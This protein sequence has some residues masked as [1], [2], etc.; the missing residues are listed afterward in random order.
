[1]ESTGQKGRIQVSQA[2]ADIL[3]DAG[4]AHWLTKRA[5]RVEAKGKGS[6]Q[7]YFVMPTSSGTR[8]T[9]STPE[10]EEARQYQ[11]QFKTTMDTLRVEV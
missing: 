2:T 5:E 1:M 11:E 6:L 10:A 7:T 4:K 9:R 8:T 3:T